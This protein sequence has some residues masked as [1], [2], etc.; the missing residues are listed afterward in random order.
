M[1]EHYR[2]IVVFDTGII[3]VDEKKIGKF[4]A[5]TGLPVERTSITLDYFLGL[6]PGI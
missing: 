3:P 1:F 6:V 2:R 5:F 4:S